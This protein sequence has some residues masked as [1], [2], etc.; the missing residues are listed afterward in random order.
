MLDYSSLS[1]RHPISDVLP[2]SPLLRQNR[3]PITPK[4]QIIPAPTQKRPR[5][6]PR[7]IDILISH[8][9]ALLRILDHAYAPRLPVLLQRVQD[10]RALSGSGPIGAISTVAVVVRAL[11]RGCWRSTDLSTVDGLGVGVAA[12]AAG[13][14]GVEEVD[15]AVVAEHVGAFGAVAALMITD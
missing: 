9:Q 7:R 1:S 13:A 4:R 10:C 11:R 14:A 12:G 2:S 5:I 3:P 8:D 6:R 15:V